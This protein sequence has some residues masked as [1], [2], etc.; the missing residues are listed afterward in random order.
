MNR[1]LSVIVLACLALTLPNPARAAD[2]PPLFGESIDVRVVNVE[3]VVTDRSGHRVTGLKP[4]DFR[5]R[6]DGK[7]VP[8]EYFS[9]VHDGSALPPL[10]ESA[11][12]PGA[13]AKAAPETAVQGLTEGP[14]GTYYLVFV[15][16]FFAISAQRNAVLIAMKKD[17]ARL[18]PNDRMAIVAYD[19]GRLA[20]LSNWSGAQADL[21]RALDAATA[22]K[23]RGFDRRVE[24]T[25]FDNDQAF[26]SQATA[27]GAP[28]MPA[29]ESTQSLLY[30][31]MLVRQVQGDVQAAV[32]AMRAF[33]APRGRKVMLLLSGGWPFSIQSYVEGEGHLPHR[34]V[35][36]GEEI[37]GPLARAA[38]LLGYTLYPVDV[39]GLQMSGLADINGPAPPFS[40][41]PVVGSTTRAGSI[42]NSTSTGGA[43]SFGGGDL[44]QQEVQGSLTY[45]AQETGGKALLNSN[46]TLA[47]ASPQEDTRSFYQLGFSPSWQRNDKNHRIQVEP[48]QAGLKVRS[49]TGFLDLSR[50][51]EVSM[52][53]QSALLLGTPP[54]GLQM[55][56]QL[57][58]PTR[59]R[60]GDTELPI[61]L[62]LPVSIMTVVPVGNKYAVQLEL[63]FAASDDLGNDSEVPVV[64]V[65]LTSDH[66][67][68]PGHFVRYSTKL[69]L[70]G[71]S[72]HLVAAI[73][74][75][76]SGK[77]ATAETDLAKP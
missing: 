32:S 16:D 25:S 22:R 55:P 12:Q 20:L 72:N 31:E 59:S 26:T 38:N 11:P 52:E 56:M 7:E 43:R 62:G 14:V 48:R 46:R 4:G 53:V 66:P 1:S 33:A 71:K 63:R 23:T 68:A 75:P 5:L 2:E 39:P 30:E 64:P 45:L 21:A 40:D 77:I 37:F 35:P 73:Y 60:R 15:D 50:K 58:T 9:E 27:D 76:L 17:L 28:L 3:A 29:S 67:P 44:R 19:G 70:H 49:R 13:A 24:G 36:E 51:A 6:V 74:D 54:G 34:Q 18:G 47:L 10:A 57:G 61:T 8:I 69:T 41:Q 65:T 42:A